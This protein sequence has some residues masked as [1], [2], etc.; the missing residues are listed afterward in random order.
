VALV[1]YQRVVVELRSYLLTKPNFGQRDLLATLARLEADAMVR[2]DD[3]RE[4]LAR[5]GEEVAEAVL[6]LLP[7]PDPSAIPPG[8]APPAATRQALHPSIAPE[9]E[10][11]G[12]A[13]WTHPGSAL[14]LHR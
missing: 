12:D 11:E 9:G 8:A 14:A 5:F 6:N 2:D 13:S 4:W 3:Y 7:T 1:D 10:H